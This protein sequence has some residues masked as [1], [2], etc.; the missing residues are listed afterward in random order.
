MPHSARLVALD[1]DFESDGGQQRP[2]SAVLT[3]AP[4]LRTRATSL[5]SF[6]V[7]V[8]P[9]VPRRVFWQI[10]GAPMRKLLLAGILMFAA[11]SFS[12]AA[13]L[14][15]MGTLDQ[16]IALGNAGCQ[17]GSATF[18]DFDASVLLPT[19]DPIAPG[20]VT[21]TPSGLGLQFSLTQTAM[22]GDLFD[23]LIAFS[24]SGA[25]LTEN[26]LSLA[27]ANATEDSNVTAVQD[28]CIGGLFGGTDP[29]APCPGS[30]ETSIV[31]QDAF[32]LVS[33]DGTLFVPVAKVGAFLQITVD[34]GL[35]GTAELDGSVSTVFQAIAVSEPASILLAGLGL[36]GYY[37]RRRSLRA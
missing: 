8:T 37:I 23:I 35:L 4:R 7:D 28:L 19:A 15:V 6:V 22:P 5:A 9:C 27:G 25:T 1:R 33:P 17:I 14:C 3:K 26:L 21:V 20:S 2:E 34:G 29:T 30:V 10:K 13:P 16:F 11:P 31:A 24:I 32:E 18:F 12:Q 36:A